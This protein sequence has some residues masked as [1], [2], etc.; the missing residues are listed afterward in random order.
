MRRASFHR[1]VLAADVVHHA[2]HHAERDDGDRRPRRL[3]HRRDHAGTP[4]RARQMSDTMGTSDTLEASVRSVA[5]VAEQVFAEEGCIEPVAFVQAADGRMEMIQLDFS[6]PD[7]KNYLSDVVRRIC[8]L[9]NARR[10]PHGDA[11]ASLRHPVLVQGV[12]HGAP[13]PGLH[14][15]DTG[16]R[17]TFR[18]YIE[19]RA[20]LDHEE[21]LNKW[22]H[23]TF[24]PTRERAARRMA[25]LEIEPP[26]ERLPGRLALQCRQ[27]RAGHVFGEDREGDTLRPRDRRHARS[28]LQASGW[29]ASI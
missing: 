3:D 2:I 21:P 13:P 4:E 28:S 25:M 7:A 19:M 23:V 5:S 1:G 16:G 29:L 6:D 14:Q 26:L 10:P 20:R 17:V 11:G 18:F 22:R 8:K 24:F 12:C 15:G 27:A 9:G